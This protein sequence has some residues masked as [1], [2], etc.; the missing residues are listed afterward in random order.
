M[1]FRWIARRL[2]GTPPAAGNANLPLADGTTI[3][4]FREVNTSAGLAQPSNSLVDASTE[5]YGIS[6]LIKGEIREVFPVGRGTAA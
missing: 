1:G 3:S 6:V 4:R 2:A 5:Y